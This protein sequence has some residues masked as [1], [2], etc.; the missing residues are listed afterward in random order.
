[1][2][3]YWLYDLPNVLLGVVVTSAFVLFAVAGHVL[4]RKRIGSNLLSRG[5]VLGATIS[6]NAH[7]GHLAP[8]A[9][10]PPA[11]GGRNARYATF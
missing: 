10:Y 4:L 9:R 6:C 2:S 3:L 8:I 11:W 5:Q 1:M 7:F